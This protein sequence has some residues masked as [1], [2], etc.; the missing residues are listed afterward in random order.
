MI[1][2]QEGVTLIPLAASYFKRHKWEE[3]TRYPEKFVATGHGKKTVGYAS[4]TLENGHF[5]I[6]RLEQRTKIANG[7]IKSTNRTF[8]IAKKVGVSVVAQA[9]E[10]LPEP[11][12]PDAQITGPEGEPLAEE[13]AA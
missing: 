6:H 8:E 12:K 11:K 7:M 3:E 9:H 10:L 1:E 4:A 2:E 13:K 5:I